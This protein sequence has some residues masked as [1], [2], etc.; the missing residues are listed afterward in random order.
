MSTNR[1]ERIRATFDEA[2]DAPEAARQAILSSRCGNDADLRRE[3]ESLL[4]HAKHVGA[5][6]VEESEEGGPSATA[7]A[8]WARTDALEASSALRA[9]PRLQPMD[10]VGDYVIEG[11]LAR[12]AA[13]EVYRARRGPLAIALKIV[14]ADSV[15]EGD[16][17]RFLEGTRMAATTSHPNLAEVHEC[18]V[19]PIGEGMLFAAMRLV[20]GPTLQTLLY[21]RVDRHELPSGAVLW[22]LVERIAEV[23]SALGALHRRTIAHRDVKPGNIV[24]KGATPDGDFTGRAVLV[25]FGLLRRFDHPTIHSTLWGTPAYAA[26]ETL[27]E[28]RADARSDV[29]SLGSCLIDLVSASL[30]VHGRGMLRLSSEPLRCLRPDVDRRL[31]AIVD[32]ATDLLP[33]RRYPDGDAMARDLRAWLADAPIE[34]RILTRRVLFQRWMQHHPERVL[35]G[36]WRGIAALLVLTLLATT[37]VHLLQL[38]SAARIARAAWSAGDIDRSLR[39]SEALPQAMRSE[40]LPRELAHA[41]GGTASEALDEP[42]VDLVKTIQSEGGPAGRLLAARYLER[43]GIAMQPT[44]LGYLRF[45]LG[46]DAALESGRDDAIRILARLFFDHPLTTPEEVQRAEHVRAELLEVL[47]QRPRGERE[48]YALCAL[49]GCGDADTLAQLLDWYSSRFQAVGSADSPAL[50]QAMQAME[51]LVLRSEACGYRAQLSAMDWASWLPR[52]SEP[53]ARL[54]D[55]FGANT[56]LVLG[57]EDL[58]VAVASARR[59]EGLEPMPLRIALALTSDLL[60][61]A[62]SGAIELEDAFQ[63]GCLRDDPACFSASHCIGLNFGRVLALYGDPSFTTATLASLQ[64]DAFGLGVA[65]APLMRYVQVGL[66]RGCN[67]RYGLRESWLPD[68]DTRLGSWF[69]NQDVPPAVLV[70]DDFD[71]AS[72]EATWS[73]LRRGVQMSGGARS[74]RLTCTPILGDDANPDDG[75]ARLGVAGISAIEFAFRFAPDLPRSLEV[76]IRYQ[77]AARRPLPFHGEA[78]V[79]IDLDGSTVEEGLW[80]RDDIQRTL[81]LPITPTPVDPAPYHELRMRLLPSSSTTFRIHEVTI[82]PP[83]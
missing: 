69:A 27:F 26:P 79:G 67:E 75:F 57:I 71:E 7:N 77:K 64:S 76:R 83:R 35:A 13:S 4:R 52:C 15:G 16:L 49:G 46:S 53:V 9:G 18:G 6:A 28:G 82:R 14:R 29:F 24:I 32:R 37:V 54:L 80:V 36:L 38:F 19:A 34:A 48:L 68:T 45:E 20:K 11:L 65:I 81:I 10:R 23:A 60:F 33:E 59:A 44:L 8:Q 47:R 50:F 63:P 5:F 58:Y 40:L 42:I 1:D 41:L 30:P 39:A 25:D 70:S 22:A 72:S 62:A 61:L 66:L 78:R 17:E 21:E 31:E 12:G 73:F 43:D 2:L 74:L 51:A 56:D 3:V 55:T